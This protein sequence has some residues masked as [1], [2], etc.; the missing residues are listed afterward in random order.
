MS[1]RSNR[2]QQRGEKSAYL[3]TWVRP[4]T[5]QNVQERAERHG[6]SVAQYLRRLAR[7]KAADQQ[8]ATT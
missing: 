7:E 3:S 4:A 8:A 2:S 6:E 5:K 1:S